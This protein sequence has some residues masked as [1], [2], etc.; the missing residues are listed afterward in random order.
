VQLEGEF[1]IETIASIAGL[2]EIINT[3]IEVVGG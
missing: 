2:L 3:L 1:N